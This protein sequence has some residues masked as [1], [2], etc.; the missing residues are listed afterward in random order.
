MLQSGSPMRLVDVGQVWPA[1]WGVESMSGQNEALL[2]AQIQQPI[3]DYRSTV[4]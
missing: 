4:E 2:A 3:M 1:G